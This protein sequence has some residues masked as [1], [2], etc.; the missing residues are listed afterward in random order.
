MMRLPKWA[1][2][3]LWRIS[4]QS[5]VQA[6]LIGFLKSHSPSPSAHAASRKRKKRAS[7]KE[8]VAA[9][10][11]VV[12]ARANGYCECGCALRFE[13]T[14]QGRPTWDEFYGR[15]PENIT[16]EK[17]WLLRWD[18]HV[19]KTENWPT[20]ESWD[21]WFKKHCARYGYEFTPRLVKALGPKAK[22]RHSDV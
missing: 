3:Q 1:Y 19:C 10:R 6:A 7:R 17:T 20:R 21:L 12:E 5:G 8:L 16:P 2:K 18:H 14:P 13:D 11:P 9:V 22:E 15:D 4:G